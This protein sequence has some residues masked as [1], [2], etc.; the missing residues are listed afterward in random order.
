MCVMVLAFG[1]WVFWKQR[2]KVSSQACDHNAGA[3]RGLTEAS[4]A[5]T[6]PAADPEHVRWRR[7][8]L[9][10]N[11]EGW[12]SYLCARGLQIPGLDRGDPGIR[13]SAEPPRFPKFR[14]LGVVAI[15]LWLWESRA[16]GEIPVVSWAPR[17]GHRGEAERAGPAP[18]R[19]HPARAK[20]RPGCLGGI[21]FPGTLGEEESLPEL[22]MTK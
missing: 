9:I 21:P 17:E 11:A 15:N 18:P 14:V 13:G 3:L 7:T 10:L 16:A 8:L 1:E 2:P 5:P 19:T 4:A 22:Q 12:G 20:G 6:E